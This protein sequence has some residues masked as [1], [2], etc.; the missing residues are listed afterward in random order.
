MQE[1]FSVKPS[2]LKNGVPRF[3]SMG[4]PCGTFA[5]SRKLGDFSLKRANLGEIVND[6][7]LRTSTPVD[8]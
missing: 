7:T 1:T 2:R 5:A 4:W 8:L 3:R 6:G